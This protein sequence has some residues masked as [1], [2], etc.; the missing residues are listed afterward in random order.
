MNFSTPL[1][2][3]RTLP[4]FVLLC[5]LLAAGTFTARAQDTKTHISSDKIF[6]ITYPVKW[7]INKLEQAELCING[8]GASLFKPSMIKIEIT[9]LAEGYEKHDIKKLSE[10]ETKM[11]KSQ[12]T[13]KVSF[14]IE[15]SKFEKIKGAE[16]WT[17]KG[18]ITQGKEIFL[19][20]SHKAIYK[21][22]VY[23]V[24][25]LATEKKFEENRAAAKAIFD[26]FEF[27]AD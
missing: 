12:N 1:S 17:I 2:R 26:T 23:T 11:A 22:K 13:D 24:T 10:V 20:D 16:W 5:T 8:P 7:K 14:T 25:Y 4:F 6:M 27:M 9:K 15:E 18:K 21:G 19:T 3:Y